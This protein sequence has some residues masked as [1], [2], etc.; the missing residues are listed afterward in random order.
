M[1]LKSEKSFEKGD[2]PVAIKIESTSAV[3]VMEGKDNEFVPKFYH[4]D[5]IGEFRK[6]HDQWALATLAVCVIGIRGA[7]GR[8][9]QLLIADGDTENDNDI[10]AL[11]PQFQVEYNQ[12]VEAFNNGLCIM[13]L[14][15]NITISQT[16]DRY[17]C[18]NASTIISTVVDNFVQEQLKAIH[19]KLCVMTQISSREVWILFQVFFLN[20]YLFII[21]VSSIK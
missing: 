16:G 5:S 17:L 6:R 12:I 9:N 14:F 15:K 19:S 13:V 3:N 18:T 4:T 10:I 2:M 1:S 11:G 20:T 7:Y 21:I 8:F